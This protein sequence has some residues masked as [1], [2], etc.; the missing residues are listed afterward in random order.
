[1]IVFLICYRS[2]SVN[3]DSRFEGAVSLHVLV[4]DLS[5]SHFRS[6]HCYSIVIQ[7]LFKFHNQSSLQAQVL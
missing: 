6:S 4:F 3:L 1:M 7:F 5:L 2:P